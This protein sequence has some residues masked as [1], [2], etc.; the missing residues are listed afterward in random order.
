M[1]ETT[2]PAPSETACTPASWSAPAVD[3]YENDQEFLVRADIPGVQKDAMRVTLAGGELRIFGTT[4]GHEYRRRFDVPEGID[5][6]TIEAGLEHGV[7]T[8]HLP[9]TPE[10]QPR[11]IP[12]TVG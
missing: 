9:K 1:T 12:V 8:V 6:D 5:A 3:I 2:N 4:H 11:Q 7:L 10:Q